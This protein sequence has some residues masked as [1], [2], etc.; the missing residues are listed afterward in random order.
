M[1]NS[2]ILSIFARLADR[3]PGRYIRVASTDQQTARN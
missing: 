3:I 1:S 2:V